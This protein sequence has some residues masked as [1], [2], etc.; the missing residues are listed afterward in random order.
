[1][2]DVFVFFL[3]SAQITCFV[4]KGFMMG[5]CL[6]SLLKGKKEKAQAF[7][8]QMLPFPQGKG[9]QDLH[10]LFQSWTRKVL[11]SCYHQGFPHGELGCTLGNVTLPI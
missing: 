10:H 8:A 1:M 2:L 4:M 9:P 6:C 3:A 11:A 7:L 5:L